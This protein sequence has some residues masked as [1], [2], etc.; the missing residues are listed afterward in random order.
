MVLRVTRGEV[1]YPANPAAGA[2]DTGIPP[3]RLLD[4]LEAECRNNTMESLLAP[5]TTRW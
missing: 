3:G 4:W 5:V 2:I 1:L